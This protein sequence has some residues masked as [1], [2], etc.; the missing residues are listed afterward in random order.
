MELAIKCWY[1]LYE[2]SCLIHVANIWSGE[3][4]ME[5]SCIFILEHFNCRVLQI[6]NPFLRKG[7]SP[8]HP[9]N[10]NEEFIILIYFLLWSSYW[11]QHHF[12]WPIWLTDRIRWLCI[13][14]SHYHHRA[15]LSE[16]I[17]LIKCLSDIFCQV[18]KIKHILSLLS[19]I[20][21]MRMCVSSLPISL[22]MIERISICPIIIIKSEVW[23]IIH[24]L[25]LGH[26]TM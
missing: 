24:C 12:D 2:Y 6:R 19:I 10:D 4:L 11:S 3:K 25:G 20:H 18:C 5:K 15:N 1:T 9:R 17:E 22:V 14:S 8:F 13:T 7:R 21:Y 26:E 23:N 16:D